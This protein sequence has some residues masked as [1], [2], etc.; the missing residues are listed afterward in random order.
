MLSL[1]AYA[2]LHLSSQ[3]WPQ[4]AVPPLSQ[5][6]CSFIRP[7][8]ILSSDTPNILLVDIPSLCVLSLWTISYSYIRSS[9]RSS[10]PIPS[11]HQVQRHGPC[12]RLR[13]DLPFQGALNLAACN[14][15]VQTVQ[16][17]HL[18]ADSSI[19]VLF[20]QLLHT[21]RTGKAPD[22]VLRC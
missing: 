3:K 1:R 17:V 8:L 6:F 15:H 9:L 22:A 11:S 14:P 19:R 16:G 5:P 21:P 12:R 13:P 18:E 4:I 2:L 7:P 20:A 10:A